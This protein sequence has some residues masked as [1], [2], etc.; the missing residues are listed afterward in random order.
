MLKSH[1]WKSK[2]VCWKCSILIQVQLKNFFLNSCKLSF[3]QFYHQTVFLF[4]TE[5]SRF[6]RCY[7]LLR[8]SYSAATQQPFYV[9][10]LFYE[11]SCQFKNWREKNL[12]HN[13]IS[14]KQKIHEVWEKINF[15][16]HFSYIWSVWKFNAKL[17]E[18]WSEED[19]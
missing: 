18:F 14:F 7:E 3:N 8:S 2:Q 9:I 11:S 1:G 4:F 15:F 19:L 13:S 6:A 16:V 17:F 12:L 5:E 10:F